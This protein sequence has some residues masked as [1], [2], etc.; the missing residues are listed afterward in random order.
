[1]LGEKAMREPDG[2]V[3]DNY[4]IVEGTDEAALSD[5]LNSIESSKY[6][7]TH[8][9]CLGYPWRRQQG[10]YSPLHRKELVEEDFVPPFI[11]E[12]VAA[13]RRLG[14]ALIENQIDRTPEGAIIV[15]EDFEDIPF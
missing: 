10:T 11:E 12:I 4:A 8:P 7:G 1:M 3:T 9:S 15:E 14:D 6:R 2:I 13:T 5:H